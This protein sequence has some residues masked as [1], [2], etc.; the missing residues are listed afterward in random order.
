MSSIFLDIID[1]NGSVESVETERISPK[2]AVVESATHLLVTSQ[3]WSWEQLR[4]YVL[5]EIQKAHGPQVRNIPK[6][7][8]IFKSFANR[9][10]DKASAIARYAFEIQQGYWHRAPITVGRFAKGSDEYFAQVIVD[11]L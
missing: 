5:T 7:N 4:D 1:D 8:A 10:G 6:E 3:S 2:P 9:W 11:Q